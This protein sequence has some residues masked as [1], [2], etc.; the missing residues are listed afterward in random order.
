MVGFRL[1]LLYSLNVNSQVNAFSPGLSI[2]C[3]ARCEHESSLLYAEPK[4]NV[5]SNVDFMS[6]RKVMLSLVAAAGST[7][8]PFSAN[9]R[10]PSKKPAVDETKSISSASSSSVATGQV[11]GPN[12]VPLSILSV[13]GFDLCQDTLE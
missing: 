2:A 1:L 13:G 9:A 11:A 12:F 4:S 5:E 6:R 8:A 7:M 10:T 3:N